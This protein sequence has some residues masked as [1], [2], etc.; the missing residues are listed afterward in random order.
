MKFIWFFSLI[1]LMSCEQ[2]DLPQQNSYS[3]Q[4][5]L[6]KYI[7]PTIVNPGRTYLTSVK[8]IGGQQVDSVRLDIFKN[9]QS[10]S[11]STFWLYDDGSAIYQQDGDQV[12]FD[13]IFTQNI[14]WTAETNTQKFVWKFQ[15]TDDIGNTSEPL[16]QN[17][18]SVKNVAPVLL[19]VEC[20]DSLDSAFDGQLKFT[21]QVFDSNGTAIDIDK[22]YYLAYKDDV[23]NFQADLQPETT[24]GIYS[25]SVDY[26]F[27]IGK[28]GIYE[29]Q[30]FAKDKS[31]EQSNM[32][33]KRINIKNNPP[34][35]SNFSHI[36]SVTIPQE[37]RMVAF[38]INVQVDDDQTLSDVKHV[39]MEWKKP[40]GSYSLNSPFDLYDN[41]L[42]WDEDFEGWDDGWRGDEKAD[43]GIFSITG[44]FDPAQPLGD[45]QLTFYA[46]DYAG[47]KSERITRIITLLPKEGV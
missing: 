22:V 43:D 10:Q 36:D 44:I 35:L 16:V 2:R 12:A 17:I 1:L 7:I 25:Q 3:E 9:S 40:D 26:T 11:L 32:I 6:E 37:G 29:Y 18:S 30:F 46:E 45:Y 13:R 31:G 4:L 47:N 8:V 21:A 15:A 34:V 14:L 42:P 20:P 19:N 5:T 41:G 38:L 27:A 39:K 33:K 24:E 28:K 23:L